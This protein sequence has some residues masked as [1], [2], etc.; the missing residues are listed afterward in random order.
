[1]TSMRLPM[2]IMTLMGALAFT[3]VSTRAEMF[4]SKDVL[5]DG[6][7]CHEKFESIREDTL[8]SSQPV[9]KD[10]DDIV[11][12]YG[13]CNHAPLSKEEI[14]SQKIEMQHRYNNEYND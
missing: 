9:L 4:L 1:M 14:Q 3:P 7:Y 10:V 11:D 2:A 13:P 5:S 6:S 8:A 12:F